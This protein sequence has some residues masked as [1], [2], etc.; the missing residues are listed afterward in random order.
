[1]TDI[2]QEGEGGSGYAAHQKFVKLGERRGDF[3]EVIEGLDANE[4]VVTD[5][6]FKLYPGASVVLQ[7]ERAPV[8]QL[9]PTPEDS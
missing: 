2:T 7:D 4:R 8:A 1:M 3:V 9:E 6:A 5:G